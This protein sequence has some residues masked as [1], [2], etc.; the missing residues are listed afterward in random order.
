MSLYTF[1]LITYFFQM[2]PQN[3]QPQPFFPSMLESQIKGLLKNF[4]SRS[5]SWSKKEVNDKNE[6]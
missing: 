3:E 6:G 5:N 2:A 1:F 4:T